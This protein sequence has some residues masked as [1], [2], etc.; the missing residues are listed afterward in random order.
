[1]VL[2]IAAAAAAAAQTDV[3]R[4]GERWL[5]HRARGLSAALLLESPAGAE[6]LVDRHPSFM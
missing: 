5:H 3:R 4:R 2:V 6:L 1:M